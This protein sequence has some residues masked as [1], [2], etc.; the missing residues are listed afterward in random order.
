MLY[1]LTFFITFNISS[2]ALPLDSILKANDAISLKHLSQQYNQ[3]VFL[4]KLCKKQKEMKKIPKACY[5]LVLKADFWCLK[6]KLEDPRI[7]K[8][9]E[10]ALKSKFLSKKC[11]DHLEQQK[12]ILNYKQEDFLLP[13]LKNYFTAEKP[14]F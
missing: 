8:N 10:K 6:L 13:E 7:L 4:E 2:S 3:A 1:Y 12:K 14:F 9:I 11:R 5:E